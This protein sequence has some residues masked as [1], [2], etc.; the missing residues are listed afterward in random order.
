MTTMTTSAALVLAGPAFSDR[1]GGRWRVLGRVQ[2]P[3]PRGVTRWA[4][5]RSRSGRPAASPVPGQSR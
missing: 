2:R 5:A 3:D 1:S 4:C